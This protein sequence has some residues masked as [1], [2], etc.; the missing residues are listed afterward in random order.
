MLVGSAPDPRRAR[1]GSR[2]RPP[3]GHDLAHGL[4]RDPPAAGRDGRRRVPLRRG[5]HDRG[6]RTH[7]APRVHQAGRGRWAGTQ[8]IDR[9]GGPEPGR[10]RP[11]QGT[12][13]G[14][15]PG[16]L[17]G[18]LRRL[19]GRPRAHVPR[20]HPDRHAGPVPRL[21]ERHRR[22]VAGRGGRAGRLPRREIGHQSRRR[23]PLPGAAGQLRS[24]R[25]QGR[26]A[27]STRAGPCAPAPTCSPRGRPASWGRCSPTTPTSRSRPPGAST[28]RW[29]PPTASPTG[30]A[31]AT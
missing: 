30:P 23:G 12:A 26:P 16:T 27:V 1:L 15:G 17:R 11:H 3:A 18:G 21:Q 22:P 28:R 31:A 7:L 25:P 19:A 9:D 4:G 10:R 2:D 14:S 24:P 20:R 6:G 5:R 8:G 29:S 13:A